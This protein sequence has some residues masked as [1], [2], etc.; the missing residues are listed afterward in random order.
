MSKLTEQEMADM[1]A[2]AGVIYDTATLGV[3][4]PKRVAWADVGNWTRAAYLA[5]ASESLRFVATESALVADLT[6]QRDQARRIAVALEQE[7]AEL[8]RRLAEVQS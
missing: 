7:V 4:P 1:S 8:T 3:K 5:M 2:L 6:A